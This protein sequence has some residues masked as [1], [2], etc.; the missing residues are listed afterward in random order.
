MSFCCLG[1]AVGSPPSHPWL[2]LVSSPGSRRDADGLPRL[3]V[4]ARRGVAAG[5][6]LTMDYEV[7][8]CACGAGGCCGGDEGEGEGEG[9]EGEEE[10]EGEGEE[11]GVAGVVV[12]KKKKK[13]RR[14]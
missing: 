8:G 1:L 12:A 11:D 5:E 10:E 9:G 3:V 14:R 7:A 4:E 2:P 6:E 13:R